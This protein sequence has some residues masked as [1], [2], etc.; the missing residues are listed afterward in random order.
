MEPLFLLVAFVVQSAGPTQECSVTG[1]VSNAAT[2]A[3]VRKAN[4]RLAGPAVNQ[5]LSDSVG[6]TDD[7]GAFHFD[8]LSPN[9]FSLTVNR[10]GFLE[11]IAS[12]VDCGASDVA[13]KL[14]PQGMIFGR[15][16]DDEGE[17]VSAANVMIY[18]KAWNR[19]ERQFQ[20]VQ[21]SQS[22][23]DGTFVIGQPGRRV[24]IMPASKAIAAPHPARPSSTTIFPTL[25][26]LNPLR[27]SV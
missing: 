12:E 10:T 19:G 17:P 8:R 22:Q 20:N 21:S 3:P 2:N 11:S 7:S 25:P 9:K 15:V 18:R 26:T 23:A 13:I 4:V 6:T 5:R 14:T 16:V 24:I 27:P 1:H